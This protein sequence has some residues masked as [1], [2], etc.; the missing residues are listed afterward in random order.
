MKKNNITPFLYIFNSTEQNSLF[1]LL[2]NFAVF[3]W[4]KIYNYTHKKHLANTNSAKSTNQKSY[5][6]IN[7]LN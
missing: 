5:Q 4:A 3:L 1:H 6:L 7:N 2:L